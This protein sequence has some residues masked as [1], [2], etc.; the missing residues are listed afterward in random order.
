MTRRIGNLRVF[1]A[2]LGGRERL[3][4]IFVGIGVGIVLPL[5]LAA[6]FALSFKEPLVLLAPIPFVLAFGLPLLFRPTGFGVSRTHIAVLRP[7]GPLLIELG[8]LRRIT[9]PATQPAKPVFG[10]LRVSG[11]GGEF[12]RYWSRDWGRFRMYLTDPE[13]TVEFDLD[14]GSRLLLSPARPDRYINA[15]REAAEAAGTPI[16]MSAGD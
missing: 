15:V 13:N 3:V 2:P 16:D 4:T 8:R 12:G 11:I 14:D 7:V 1:E 9:Y 6:V 5:L 10:I